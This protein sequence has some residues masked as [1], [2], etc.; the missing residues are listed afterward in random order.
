MEF[1]SS[2]TR[3]I[4]ETPQKPP[5]NFLK[6]KSLTLCQHY[7]SR[8]GSPRLSNCFLDESSV[9]YCDQRYCVSAYPLNPSPHKRNLKGG[10]VRSPKARAWRAV[11][12]CTNAATLGT[13]LGRCTNKSILLTVTG[14][15]RTHLSL[16]AAN[17]N[18]QGQP[19][20]EGTFRMGKDL[21][22]L[23]GN[24][25]LSW[26]LDLVHLFSFPSWPIPAPDHPLRCPRIRLS[27]SF[28]LACASCFSLTFSLP[29]PSSQLGLILRMYQG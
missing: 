28:H 24:S 3:E 22:R 12:D 10:H 29:A 1:P 5:D 23:S 17:A 25:W 11:G 8:S 26:S 20:V 15:R 14:A 7:N 16:A 21:L 4:R 27:G 19:G 9:Q 13:T 18:P 2:Q 6:F